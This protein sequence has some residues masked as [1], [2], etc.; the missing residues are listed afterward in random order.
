[1]LISDIKS[2]KFV[3]QNPAEPI[4]PVQMDFAEPITPVQWIL[5][6]HSHLYKWI[7]LNQSQLYKFSHSDLIHSVSK[8]VD[9]SGR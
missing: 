6:N 7:L 5:Q 8:F 4:T 9:V 2:G 1:M 3:R